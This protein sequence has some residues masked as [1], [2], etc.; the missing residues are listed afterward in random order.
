MSDIRS[1]PP[2]REVTQ[3]FGLQP[4]KSLG[5]NFLF[6][7][8]L[9]GKIVRSAGELSG[10]HVIEIGPGP[11]GLTRAFFLEGE[12][13]H[14]T[15]IEKD[16]RAIAAQKQ[17][18][19]CVGV[20]RFTILQEDAL[21]VDLAE[22]SDKPKRIIA[23][24]PYNISTKLLTN[25]FDLIDDVSSLTLMFQKEVAERLIAMPGTKS[26]GRL[27]V[28]TQ[29]LYDV[30][31]VFDVPASAFV[32]P[33][34][35]TSSIVYLT[36]KK[37]RIMQDKVSRHDLEEITKLAFGNRRK[38]LRS[39]LKNVMTEEGFQQAGIAP[40]SRPEDLSIEEFCQLSLYSTASSRS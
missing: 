14:V 29:W 21:K 17:I 23:N 31:K 25:W 3:E 40:T 8:N 7:L 16:D 2:L 27:S 15:V 11:G 36:P 9:T 12:P 20:D 34:K 24:L 39:T 18:Q 19:D 1:L 4:K 5:Q 35:V 37:T 30:T 33:P 38:M 22:L 32:P 13:D 6:D 10:Y 26:Y 28:M